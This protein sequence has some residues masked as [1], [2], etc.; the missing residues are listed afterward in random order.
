[1]SEETLSQ[2]I[3]KGNIIAIVSLF[4]ISIVIFGFPN[5]LGTGNGLIISFS[6]IISYLILKE[7]AKIESLRDFLFKNGKSFLI[8]PVKASLN[9]NAV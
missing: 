1:M 3:G 9:S 7:I 5:D 2:L 6:A 8:N 4:L